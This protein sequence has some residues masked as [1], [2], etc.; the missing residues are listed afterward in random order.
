MLIAKTTAM[1]STSKKLVNAISFVFDSL[2]IQ[3]FVQIESKVL[4]AM[5]YGGVYV[6]SAELEK[7][8]LVVKVRPHAMGTHKIPQ[9]FSSVQFRRVLV[10]FST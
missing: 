6:A 5:E 2:K 3:Q 7:P 8:G 9:M 1:T 10:C 4:R